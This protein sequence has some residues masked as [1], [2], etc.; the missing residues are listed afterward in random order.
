MKT[1][2]LVGAL[3]VSMSL[4]GCAGMHSGAGGAESLEQAESKYEKLVEG[5]QYQPDRDEET[6]QALYRL[7]RIKGLLCKWEQAQDYLKEA[8]LWEDRISGS[9]SVAVTKKSVEIARFYS[10]RQ[11]YHA[12]LPYFDQAVSTAAGN[13]AV[14]SDPLAFAEVYEEYANAL[15]RSDRTEDAL[16]LQNEA[17]ALKAAHPGQRPRYRPERYGENC[18]ADRSADTTGWE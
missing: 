14:Q 12:S 8:L 13:G 18:S 9:D 15:I 11:D 7:G 17:A 10:D 16:P 3:L 4:A 1:G 5:L 6:T 2:Y